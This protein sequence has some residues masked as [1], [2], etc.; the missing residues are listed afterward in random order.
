MGWRDSILNEFI[1]DVSKLTLVADPDGLLTEEVLVIKLREKGFDIIEYED[2]ISFRYA[3][4][5]KYRSL[6]DRGLK[7]DLV[8]V[9]R[10]QESDLEKL[11]YDIFVTGRSLS[12]SIN[13]IFPNLSSPV[14][15]KLDKAH[16]EKLFKSQ[17]KCLTQRIGDNATR[18]FILENVFEINPDLIKTIPQLLNVLLRI[19][20]SGIELPYILNQRIIKSLKKSDEFSTWPLE[21]LFSEKKSFYEFLQERWPVFVDSYNYLKDEGAQIIRFEEKT[22]GLKYPGPVNIPFDDKDVK[23][24][25]DDLFAE[26]KL[27]PV[28]CLNSEKLKN[29]WIKFGIKDNT[30]EEFI[31]RIEQRLLNLEDSIPKPECI[32]SKWLSF[33]S[34]YARLKSLIYGKNSSKFEVSPRI[35][36]K[37][38]E[39]SDTV[40]NLFSEWL[41]KRYQSLINLPPMPPVIVNQIPR[42]LQRQREDNSSKKIALI[43]IDGLSLNQWFSVKGVLQ[44]QN[45]SLDFNENCTFAWIPTLTSVSRQAIFSGKIPFYFSDHINTTSG[46]S[47]SWKNY[48]ENSGIG[49][50]QIAYKKGLL[51]KN[52]MEHLTS[53]FNPQKTLIAGFVI[54]KID[55]IMHGMQLGEEGMHNQIEQWCKM[56]FL[57]E[58]I[59]YLQDNNFDIWI[60]SD[61]GNIESEGIGRPSEGSISGLKGERVRI[62]GDQILC[63]EVAKKYSSAIEWKTPG[64]P[65]DYYPLFASKN[66]SFTT[67]GTKSV[68]HGGISIDET[69]VPFISVFKRDQQ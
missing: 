31:S 44:S 1:T 43:V 32:H 53:V 41:Q 69:I 67:K 29:T 8:V 22:Y 9:L 20:Y 37:F 21:L 5:T 27:Q 14:I 38:T 66:S 42:Y 34:D 15:E 11:P 26:G 35:R 55:N 62:F 10:T 68:T 49:N 63:K 52:I 18:D 50:S 13:K 7:T 46:E 23:I 60:T 39:L 64:L 4:E 3:Y 57:N 24:Y 51:D 33:A 54:N 2:A 47:K 65:K 36:K 28:S 40:N 58:M 61:H 16:F 17:N 56:G 59:S 30:Q 45:P 19:H 48:W 6:W 12:F 25:I